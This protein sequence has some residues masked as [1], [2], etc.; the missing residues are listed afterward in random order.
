[1]AARNGDHGSGER[2][3]KRD[4]IPAPI[5]RDDTLSM[6]IRVGA[7]V[8]GHPRDTDAGPRGPAPSGAGVTGTATAS[9]AVSDGVTQGAAG[10]AAD[11]ALKPGVR[12]AGAYEI[13][14]LLGVGGMGAVYKGVDHRR[15]REIAI[16]TISAG[17]MGSPN[18]MA[19]FERE[20]AA[21]AAVH[22]PNIAEIHDSGVSNGIPF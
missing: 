18:A 2:P 7:A 13:V 14:R 9:S 15:G 22:H 5:P 21:A 20:V 6:P 10:I 17:H 3:P 11:E 8:D 19:R 12:P 4:A 16:K 1:M